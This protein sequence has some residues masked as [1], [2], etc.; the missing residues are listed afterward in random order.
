M[1]AN[2]PRA[3]FGERKAALF[4]ERHPVGELVA[5]RRTPGEPATWDRVFAPAYGF[6]DGAMVELASSRLPVD[7]DVV[8][9]FEPGLGNAELTGGA[10]RCPEARR[11]RA[12]VLAAAFTLGAAAA[13][14]LALAVPPKQATPP[15]HIVIDCDEPATVELPT[16]TPRGEQA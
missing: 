11:L 10:Q 15:S 4:N 14:L 9:A 2:H 6:G 1:R 7:C 16:Y 3:A 12:W 5:V 13:V 8:F